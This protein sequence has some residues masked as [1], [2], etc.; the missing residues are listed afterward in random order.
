MPSLARSSI[1]LL[2]ALLVT[3]QAHVVG[4]ALRLPGASPTALAAVGASRA[5]D[6]KLAESGDAPPL[7]Y[8]TV[9]LGSLGIFA[10]ALCTSTGSPP[11]GLAVA[12]ASVAL[13]AAGASLVESQE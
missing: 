2:C 6:V 11:T 5:L 12:A 13:M 9:G 10:A 8:A 1:F 3:V 7:A 4:H